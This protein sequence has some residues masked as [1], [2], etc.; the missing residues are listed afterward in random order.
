MY[1]S[2]SPSSTTPTKRPKT[3]K[4][5]DKNPILVSPKQQVKRHH[6]MSPTIAAA[7]KAIHPKNKILGGE[8]N[9]PNI[10]KASQESLSRK[11]PDLDENHAFVAD[12][13]AA[14]S[15]KPYDPI[16]NFLSPRPKFL[17]YQPNRWREIIGRREIERSEGSD[18]SSISSSTS[19]SFE[20]R[21][22]VS[23]DEQG[24]LDGAAEAFV[25]SSVDGLNSSVEDALISQE[26]VLVGFSEDGLIKPEVVS[27]GFLE[28]GLIKPEDASIDCSTEDASIDCST[29]DALIVPQEALIAFSVAGSNHETSPI[30]VSQE[31]LIASSVAGSN[32]ETSPI[33]VV[34]QALISCSDS[35][36]GLIN[37]DNSLNAAQEEVLTTS[38]ENGFINHTETTF[39]PQEALIISSFDSAM[40][41]ETTFVPAQEPHIGSSTDG[42]TMQEE[43]L[44]EETD[45]EF[46]EIEEVRGWG[47][48]FI[49]L[50]KFLL[51]LVALVFSTSYI[52]TMNSP[53][54]S[55]QGL[56]SL[57]SPQS[58]Y[59]VQHSVYQF[60]KSCEDGSEKVAELQS[61]EIEAVEVNV[62]EE[63][64]YSDELKEIAESQIAEIDKVCDD[65][66]EKRKVIVDQM[67]VDEYE[68]LHE[69]Q[70][71][72][73]SVG[74]G[75]IE[76]KEFIELTEGNPEKEII[77]EPIEVNESHTDQLCDDAIE[78]SREILDQTAV[79]EFEF[80]HESQI[81]VISDMASDGKNQ[82]IME[83]IEVIDSVNTDKID[84][85]MDGTENTANHHAN[86]EIVNPELFP[87]QNGLIEQVGAKL[88]VFYVVLV[89]SVLMC[90]GFIM[91]KE[92]VKANSSIVAKKSKLIIPSQS[93]E[94]EKIKNTSSFK[95]S[96]SPMIN[97]LQEGV[98]DSESYESKT[99][100][101][102]SFQSQGTKKWMAE[103]E[104]SCQSVS[105]ETGNRKKAKSVS[106]YSQPAL[107][108]SSYG[109]FTTEKIIF[110]KKKESGEIMVTP[111]RRSS[112]LVSRE[113]ASP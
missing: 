71:P 67:T 5:D 105:M 108:D 69:M 8:N 54:L 98:G 44:S 92:H 79:E 11:A 112:R 59:S 31:A 65:E 101:V 62:D 26:E 96:S 45:D 46:E 24:S 91:N 38:V 80:S 19:C 111:V 47:L 27:V 6:Y 1:G 29:E 72:M 58:H 113:I 34:Q 85:E 88:Y 56:T 2:S 41:Q 25:G 109:S 63:K 10:V 39:V 33:V 3:L 49:R 51:V 66:M 68:S 97:S 20:S 18:M 104:M 95:K 53:S 22:E 57:E 9:H 89:I 32:H 17:R 74:V 40:K 36:N 60:V 16:T 7:S 82:I 102:S 70:I 64:I 76:N 90:M 75:N 110:K 86:Q 52:T 78:K 43:K 21:K 107:S 30:V 13:A 15:N 106:S 12:S 83:P 55:V 50:L 23:E 35:E 4:D 103:S 94:K 28:D 87:S 100:E 61:L 48:S 77:M 42:L 84:D 99:E 37:N 93:E 81:Q 14:A 73:L